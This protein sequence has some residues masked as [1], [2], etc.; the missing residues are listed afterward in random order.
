M[1]T[2]IDF[3]FKDIDKCIDGEEET[4]IHEADRVMKDLLKTRDAVVIG[5]HT[6]ID[7]LDVAMFDYGSTMV[8]GVPAVDLN[9]G[10]LGDMFASITFD[11]QK[12][13]LSVIVYKTNLSL[14]VKKYE[15]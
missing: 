14:T 15:P 12:E 7:K 1:K 3:K 2:T 4:F 5:E 6:C 13:Y 10:M 11:P 8:D 9:I